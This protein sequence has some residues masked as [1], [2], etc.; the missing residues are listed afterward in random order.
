PRASLRAACHAPADRSPLLL[1]GRGRP[2]SALDRVRATGAVDRRTGTYTLT[3]CRCRPR[4]ES[5]RRCTGRAGEWSATS[6]PVPDPVCTGWA[7]RPHTPTPAATTSATNSRAATILRTIACPSALQLY[8][9][10]VSCVDGLCGARG[11]PLAD[12]FGFFEWCSGAGTNDSGCSV[13]HATNS[14]SFAR[15]ASTS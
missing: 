3:F 14:L 6:V 9:A 4:Q 12:R 13:R 7:C 2:L 1:R 8:L 15:T 11:E 10:A 5:S